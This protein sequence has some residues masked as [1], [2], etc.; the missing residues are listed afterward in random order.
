LITAF[1]IIFSLILSTSL[2]PHI[3]ASKKTLKRNTTYISILRDTIP[4]AAASGS[5][6]ASAVVLH[7]KRRARALEF[8]DFDPD[9]RKVFRA[10]REEFSARE[11]RLID[12]QR[13][14]KTLSDTEYI[15]Y[16]RI[17]A[18]VSGT[19]EGT[20]FK[21]MLNKLRFTFRM[22]GSFTANIRAEIE[23]IDPLRLQEIFWSSAGQIGEALERKYRKKYARVISCII[24]ERADLMSAMLDRA[25]GDALTQQL[26]DEYDRAIKRC[27]ENERAILNDYLKSGR[28]TEDEAD[29]LRVEINTMENFA[30]ENVHN[31]AAAKKMIKARVT[32][33]HDRVSRVRRNKDLEER[34]RNDGL[35]NTKRTR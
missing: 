1:A 28:I 34:R 21:K 11:F 16:Y 8:E 12:Q 26:H 18:A 14:D 32:Q 2:L 31:N 30:I 17:L 4:T 5:A 7:L 22:V 23:K 20:I 3:A 15:C 9:E 29:T 35:D 27:F 24:E 13:R 19:Q 10:M 6:C 25:F 33:R